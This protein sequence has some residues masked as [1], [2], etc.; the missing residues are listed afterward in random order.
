MGPTDVEIL[1][2]RQVLA[3]RDPLLAKADAVVP[4]TSW[5]VRDPGFPGL[6]YQIIGQQVSIAAAS[7]IRIRF[8]EG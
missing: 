5:R 8:T 7:A 6:V 4:A 1:A 3:A 2:A